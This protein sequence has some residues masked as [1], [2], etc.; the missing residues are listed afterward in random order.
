MRHATR[1]PGNI[2]GMGMGMGMEMRWFQKTEW[3]ADSG[4]GMILA[5]NGYR[6]HPFKKGVELR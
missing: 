3:I 2:A 5:G 1:G 4:G 6:V